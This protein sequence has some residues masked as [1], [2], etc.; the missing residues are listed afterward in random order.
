M[1]RL[2]CICSARSAGCAWNIPDIDITL[3]FAIRKPISS[4]RKRWFH[5]RRFLSGPS[6]VERSGVE[7]QWAFSVFVLVFVL[8][9][10]FLDADRMTI[11]RVS[12]V[13]LSRHIAP[14]SA[15]PS[16]TVD[17]EMKSLWQDG[18]PNSIQCA[19]SVE[20][21]PFQILFTLPI[22]IIINFHNFRVNID[23]TSI[24]NSL[25]KLC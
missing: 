2:S 9:T 18:I 7:W 15:Q 11:N 4:I 22:H 12:V 10:I 3:I 8:V 16:T 20:Q 6:T 5:F 21:V 25:S 24:A 13:W 14:T 23:C 1:E 19:P 17:T